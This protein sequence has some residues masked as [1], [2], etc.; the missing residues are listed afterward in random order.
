M[1]VGIFVRCSTLLESSCSSLRDPLRIVNLAVV[2]RST[3]VDAARYHLL[4]GMGIGCC[5]KRMGSRVGLPPGGIPLIRCRRA[6]IG[7]VL[8]GGQLS[9]RMGGRSTMFLVR[10]GRRQRMQLVDGNGEVVW[11]TI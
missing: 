10:G 11:G 6:E 4:W 1:F 9:A 2:Y 8:M 7:R 5:R 3:V